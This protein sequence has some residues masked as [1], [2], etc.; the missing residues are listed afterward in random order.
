M[1]NIQFSDNIC[2]Y[3]VHL[4]DEQERNYLEEESHGHLPT[5]PISCF[6][7][8]YTVWLLWASP[9]STFSKQS[10]DSVCSFLPLYFLLLKNQSLKVAII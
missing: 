4:V 7:L 6:S 10:L 1:Q 3:Q 9:L 2:H 5:L 8:V